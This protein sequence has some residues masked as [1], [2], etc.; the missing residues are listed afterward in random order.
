MKE[1]IETMLKPFVNAVN[2]EMADLKSQFKTERYHHGY[3]SS[4]Y[5]TTN[6]LSDY[7]LK[8]LD[9]LI[10]TK[11]PSESTNLDILLEDH[12]SGER[13][14]DI[15][16]DSR[17]FM[18]NNQYKIIATSTN[19][20]EPLLIDME[21]IENHGFTALASSFIKKEVDANPYLEII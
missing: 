9:F 17:L 11:D 15:R 3:G 6:W 13:K 16:F 21:E 4:L 5:G 19:V 10:E 12:K 18:E 14:A 20:D 1:H 8:H 2:K 7:D